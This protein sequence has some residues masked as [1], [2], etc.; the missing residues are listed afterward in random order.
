MSVDSPGTA[1]GS[2]LTSAGVRRNSISNMELRNSDSFDS[3]ASYKGIS[4][5]SLLGDLHTV[6][7]LE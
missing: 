4:R 1:T 5:P 6:R 2:T 7:I 3:E